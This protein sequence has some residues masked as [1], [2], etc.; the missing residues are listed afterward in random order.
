MLRIIKVKGDSLSPEYKEGD[1]VVI[2][3]VPFFFNSLQ[4]GDTIVFQHPVYGTMVK[5]VERVDPDN[6]E[7]FVVGSHPQSVDSRQFGTIPQKW[8][9]GKVL[10]Q[11]AKPG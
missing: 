9:T 1:Y 3:T 6:G 4:Q 11:I 2:T 8:I 5:H 7:I 10:W